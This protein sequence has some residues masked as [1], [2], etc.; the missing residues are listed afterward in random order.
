MTEPIT[1]PT[2]TVRVAAV[3][4]EPAIGDVEA[5]LRRCEALG[6]EAGVAGAE[7]MMLPEF[8]SD[9]HGLQR[10]DVRCCPRTGRRWD[11][12]GG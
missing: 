8:F 5:N 6:D 3:Q 1:A 12:C 11:C 2:R 4:L 9:R 10:P 7:R